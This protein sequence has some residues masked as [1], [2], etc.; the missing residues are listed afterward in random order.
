MSDAISEC[1]DKAN[2][3]GSKSTE[4]SSSGTKNDANCANSQI[5]QHKKSSG[6]KKSNKKQN[7]RK[8]NVHHARHKGAPNQLATQQVFM[9]PR[10]I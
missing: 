9:K 2:S 7:Q 3:N 8:N 6:N 5:K 1:G 10:K 4:N